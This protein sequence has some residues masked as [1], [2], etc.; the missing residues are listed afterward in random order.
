MEMR[1]SEIIMDIF[2]TCTKLTESRFVIRKSKSGNVIL[3]LM[4]VGIS[5]T[6]DDEQRPVWTSLSG[7]ERTSERGGEGDCV[8]DGG[9]E[10]R[11][12]ERERAQGLLLCHCPRH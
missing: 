10:E 5:C 4:Y 2:L 11:E 3:S 7:P 9:G 8:I 6:T 12:R 1:K